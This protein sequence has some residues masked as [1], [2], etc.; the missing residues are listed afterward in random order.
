VQLKSGYFVPRSSAELVCNRLSSGRAD[1]CADL[2]GERKVVEEEAED[3]SRSNTSISKCLSTKTWLWVR[4][5]KKL[6]DWFDRPSKT[7]S[8]CAVAVPIKAEWEDVRGE[9]AQMHLIECRQICMKHR[10]V[11]DGVQSSQ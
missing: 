2:T 5:A 3:E 7:R 8:L 4:T 1:H 10:V 9:F 11:T 6:G